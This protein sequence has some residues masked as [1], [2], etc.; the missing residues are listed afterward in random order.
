MLRLKYKCNSLVLKEYEIHLSHRDVN[1]QCKLLLV[2]IGFN[3]IFRL[4]QMVI[5]LLLMIFQSSQ[6]LDLKFLNSRDA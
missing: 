2:F 6:L 4:Q 3:F 1:A 5:I